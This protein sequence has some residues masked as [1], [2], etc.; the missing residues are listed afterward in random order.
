MSKIAVPADVHAEVMARLQYLADSVIPAGPLH[1]AIIR[2]HERL[3]MCRPA[4]GE[5]PKGTEEEA[6]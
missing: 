4:A 2:D 6:G 5:K 3:K 1:D